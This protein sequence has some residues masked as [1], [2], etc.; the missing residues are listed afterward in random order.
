MTV[1]GKRKYRIKP[2]FY[3]LVAMLVALLVWGGVTLIQ[4]LVPPRVDWGRLETDQ[5]VTAILLRDERVVLSEEYARMDCL[6][7]EG[8]LVDAGEEL[9]VL[10]TS[11][12]SEKDIQNLVQLRADI[13]DYQQI[14]IL[15][16]FVDKDLESLNN[17]IRDKVDQI[18]AL[19]ARGESRGL[20][21]HERELAQLMDQRRLYMNSTVQPD[22]TLSGMYERENALIEKIN[23]TRQVIKAEG[24]GVVSY[25]LDGYESRYSIDTLDG[26]DIR[27]VSDTKDK[28]LSG[29]VAVKAGTDGVVGIGEPLYRLVNPNRWYALIV[30][31]RLQN[32]LVKGGVCDIS[33][34][35]YEEKLLT[36]HVYNVVEQGRYA[37][38]VLQLGDPIGS[39]LS[40]RLVDGHIGR[41]LEGF[42]VPAG[43]VNEKDGAQG[44]T[45]MIDGSPRFIEVEVLAQDSRHAIV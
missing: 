30:L 41:S 44:V 33:F 28:L 29:G 45:V 39:L 40:L 18:T 6:V 19:A 32:T 26:L 38:V 2:R 7:A 37:L 16:A 36:A 1:R 3:V 15:K 25:F 23:H 5:E 20:L 12:Y 10:Y 13:K 4:R 8:E 17:E 35:G 31:P 21:V 43:A 9:A 34:E 27:T 14:N 22:E 42:K 11:G 24:G